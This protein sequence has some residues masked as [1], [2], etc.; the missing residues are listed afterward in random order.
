MN[1]EILAT[2]RSRKIQT[3]VI[4]L[5]VSGALN[6]AFAIGWIHAIR[7]ENTRLLQAKIAPIQEIFQPSKTL[8]NQEVIRELLKSSYHELL[9]QLGNHLIVEEGLTRSDLALAIL[10]K[11]HHFHIAKALGEAI[12]PSQYNCLIDGVDCN[13]NVYSGLKKAEWDAITTFTKT[14][15]WPLTSQGLFNL[16]KK[17][18]QQDASLEEA[19][20]VTPEFY[21][22]TTLFSRTGL[23]LDK[24][25]ILKLLL[26]GEWSNIGNFYSA[27]EQTPSIN[28][29]MRRAFLLQYLKIPSRIA[30][31]I[32]VETDREFLVKKLDDQDIMLLLDQLLSLTPSYEKLLT[33]LLISPRAEPLKQLA[34]TKIQSFKIPLPILRPPV[35][36]QKLLPKETIY[37]VQEGDSLWKIA[38]KF[39][40]T[41]DH[42]MDI[43]DLDHEK[44]KP[45]QELRIPSR[46]P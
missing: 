40:I 7:Q 12:Y 33:D 23:N 24:K 9:G 3:L 25:I 38:K 37:I 45:G 16:L 44:L 36:G 13:L 22:I 28:L 34:M 41:I 39:Q 27:F 35:T 18:G 21:S 11:H 19:F 5:I 17:G 26:D 46:L 2:E 20:L 29:D 14:E 32:L 30:A 42:L 1:Q 15:K 8:S 6:L 31:R 10:V 43:N 4:S